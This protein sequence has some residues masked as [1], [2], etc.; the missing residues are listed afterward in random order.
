MAL[1]RVFYEDWQME[2]CGNPFAVGDE[3]AWKLVAYGRADRRRGE[4]HGAEAWVENHGGPDRETVGRVRAID[5]VHQEFLARHDPRAAEAAAL[6]DAAPGTLVFRST[7]RGLEPV[8]GP[9]TLEPVDGCPRWFDEFEEE[10][11]Q[12]PRR[13]PFRVRRAVGVLV[14]LEVSDAT[15]PEPGDRP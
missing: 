15:P 9:P 14:A 4:G 2:C 8:P 12:P 5:L 6:A 1:M 10:E 3:V 7:G 11:E 13:V